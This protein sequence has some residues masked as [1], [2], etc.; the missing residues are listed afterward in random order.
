[1]AVAGTPIINGT[2]DSADPAVVEIY[3]YPS[4]KDTLYT[5]TGIVIAPK[6]ILTAAHCLDHS[7]YTF[8][9]FY[10]PDANAY[11]GQIAMVEPFLKFASSVTI[12]PDYDRSTPF[13]ADIAVMIMADATDVTPL[14]FSRTAPTDALV[15]AAVR[16]IGYGE[17]TSGTFNNA[18]YA[19]DTIVAG[20]DSGADT[21]L[22]GDT[23]RTCVGDS[24]G[25]ALQNNVV[26]GV[27]SYS[28]A[29]CTDP[30]HYRRT[31]VY[32]EFID[33]IA[34]TGSGSGSAGSGSDSGSG[35][36]SGSDS[37]SSSGGGCST[38]GGSGAGFAIA[39]IALFRRRQ[40]RAACPARRAS[41][42]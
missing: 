14:A 6:A 17:T 8:G 31:D 9:V 24:G 10:G 19:A 30:A 18:R 26:L 36:G 20:L 35:S 29:G 3:A 7:G 11:N 16:I 25:P 27:D 1:V 5:C 28:A 2:A 40:H 39:L 38:T 34:G 32:A 41:H 42:R 13:T 4:T 23:H 37:G 22:V 33:S 15:N 21:I 12:H